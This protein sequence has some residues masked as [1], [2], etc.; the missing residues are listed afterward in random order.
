MNQGFL[1]NFIILINQ[2]GGNDPKE[3]GGKPFDLSLFIYL[4]YI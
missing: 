3:Q 4:I 2:L 1:I